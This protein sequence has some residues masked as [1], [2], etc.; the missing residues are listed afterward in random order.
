M[1]LKLQFSGGMK[2]RSKASIPISIVEQLSSRIYRV[3]EAVLRP[4]LVQLKRAHSMHCQFTLEHWVLMEDLE[5]MP[6]DKL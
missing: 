6:M 2:M 1:D 3:V 5:S 4:T